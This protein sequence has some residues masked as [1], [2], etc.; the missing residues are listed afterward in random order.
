MSGTSM[1]CPV[2]AGVIALVKT[3]NETWNGMQAA[4]QVR[5]SAENIDSKNPGYVD[6]LGK[7]RVDALSALTSESP[8]IRII[9]VIYMDDDEDGIIEPGDNISLDIEVQNYLQ[10]ITNISFELMTDDPMVEV[11]DGNTEL[12]QL[13]T[14]QNASLPKSLR[15]KVLPEAPTGHVVKFKLK[16]TAGDYLDSDYIA[17]VI[18]PTFANSDVNNIKVTVTNIGRI[19]FANID[20]AETGVGFVYNDGPNLL[21]EGAIIAGVSPNQMSNAARGVNVESDQDF[22]VTDGGNLE[23]QTPGSRSAQES[24]WRICRC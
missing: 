21:Y 16:I 7:G 20:L 2:A 18:L 8:S 3:K 17:L 13:G 4:E 10:A 9:D 11:M 1:A 5:V 23:V 12:D 24:L 19:G 14:L 15:F 6:Q 22:E